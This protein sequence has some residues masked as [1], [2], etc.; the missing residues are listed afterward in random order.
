VAGEW[1]L[2]SDP[3]FTADA[4]AG[5]RLFEINERLDWTLS[6]SIGPIVPSSR[7]SSSRVSETVWDGIVGIKGRYAFGEN[8][9][10]RL[11]YYV[12]I[13]TGQSDLTWQAVA[14]IGYAFSWGDVSGLWRYLDYDMKNSSRIET[15]H[16]NGPMIGATFHW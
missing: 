3:R 9:A 13:G 4:L 14:G 7:T 10:W 6:G 5:V 11:P 16:F 15:I 12:D 2:T 1:R 8:G